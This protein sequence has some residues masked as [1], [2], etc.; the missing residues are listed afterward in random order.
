MRKGEQTRQA[1]LDCAVDLASSHGLEGLTIGALAERMHMSKSGV[2]AHCGSREEL[3]IAVLREYERRFIDEILK[4]VVAEARGLT[5]LRAIMDRWINRMAAEALSGCIMI[6]G[7]VE[8][9]DRPGPVRDELVRMVLSWRGELSKCIAQCKQTGEMAAQ[10]D[11]ATVV[12]ELSGLMLSLHHDARLLQNSRAIP[13]TRD[14]LNRLFASYAAL[15]TPTQ[16]TQSA[17]SVHRAADGNQSKTQ[18]KAQA[19]LKG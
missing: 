5:R 1:I 9:D 13:T 4:P 10:L 7:A 12:F 8:Y 2:F 11:E 6:S 14:S 17:S 3:Q 16:A 15:P 19:A 18:I